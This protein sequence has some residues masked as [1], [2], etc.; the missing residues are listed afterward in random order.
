METSAMIPLTILSLKKKKR[1]IY[2]DSV[3][4]TSD[5]YELN[6]FLP[7]NTYLIL[8]MSTLSQELASCDSTLN[9]T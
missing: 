3:L 8:D 9:I 2:F 6:L 5:L 4:V 7:S 1:I